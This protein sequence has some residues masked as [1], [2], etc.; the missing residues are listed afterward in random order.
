MKILKFKTNVN[1]DGCVAGLRPFMNRIENINWSVETQNPD[2]ILTVETEEVTEEEIIKAVSKAG[3]K[4]E[5]I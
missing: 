3:F 2:K 5:K 4:I 1:C